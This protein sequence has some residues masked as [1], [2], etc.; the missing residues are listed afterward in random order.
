MTP[1]DREKL[2]LLITP[3]IGLGGALFVYALLSLIG[4]K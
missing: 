4:A 3:L 2:M 1:A